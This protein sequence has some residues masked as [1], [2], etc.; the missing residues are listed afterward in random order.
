MSSE[1]WSTGKIR[2]LDELDEMFKGATTSKED[3]GHS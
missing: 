2:E 3:I 1:K